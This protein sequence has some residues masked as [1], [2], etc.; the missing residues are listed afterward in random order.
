ME[1]SNDVEVS[2]IVDQSVKVSVGVS[3]D[4]VDKGLTMIEN[5][6]RLFLGQPTLPIR[7][8]SNDLPP[9]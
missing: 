7:T 5:I 2:V 8:K 9:S 6:F 3:K 4:A 1:D